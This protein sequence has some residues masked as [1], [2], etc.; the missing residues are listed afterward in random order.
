MIG[1]G[2]FTGLL[3]GA[4]PAWLISRSQISEFIHNQI[5]KGNKNPL[6]RKVLIGFLFFI[7]TALI[8]GTLGILRQANYMLNEDLGFE[9]KQLGTDAEGNRVILN[10]AVSY[11]QGISNQSSRQSEA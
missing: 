9:G 2:L 4:Y 5:S 6:L 1:T 3:S 11:L 8:I 7:S 10:H